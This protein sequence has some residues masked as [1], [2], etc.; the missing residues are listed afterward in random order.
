[1]DRLHTFGESHRTGFAG[2]EKDRW[3]DAIALENAEL[4]PHVNTKM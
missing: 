4:A 2:S 3:T 1:M